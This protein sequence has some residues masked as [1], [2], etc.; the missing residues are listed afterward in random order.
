MGDHFHCDGSF[1]GFSL[2]L[3]DRT[4]DAGNVLDILVQGKQ[5]GEPQPAI[6]GN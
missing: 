1:T 4:A 6:F 5:D 3:E 2:V